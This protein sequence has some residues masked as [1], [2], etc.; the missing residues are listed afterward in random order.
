[1]KF[2]SI[3]IFFN[4]WF[5]L[6]L[7]FLLFTSCSIPNQKARPYKSIKQIKS[8]V[9][10]VTKNNTSK[11]RTDRKVSRIIA[12]AITPVENQRNQIKFEWVGRDSI[13]PNVFDYVI[14]SS[15]V[16]RKNWNNNWNEYKGKGTPLIFLRKDQGDRFLMNAGEVMPVTAHIEKNDTEFK[17]KIFDTLD[18][19]N[20]SEE[21]ARDYTAPIN[22]LTR[23]AKLIP[24]ITAIVKTNQYMD[25]IGLHRMNPFDPNKI[26][27]ILIHGFKSNPTTWVNLINQLQSDPKV[28]NRFQFWTFSYPTGIPILYSTM[29]LRNELNAMR[30]YYDPDENNKNLSNIV[31]VGHS[32]GG[33]IARLLSS[34]SSKEYSKWPPVGSNSF[35]IPIKSNEL[36][37]KMFRFKSQDY[38]TRS[39]FIA[40]PHRGT[41]LASSGIAKMLSSVIQVP[42]E[43]QETFINSLSL[44]PDISF[45]DQQFISRMKSINNLR[46]ESNFIKYMQSSSI[47]PRIKTHSIIGIGKL[48]W[49]KKLESRN[50]FVVSYESAHLINSD[51]ELTIAAWHDL[52]TDSETISEVGRILKS[53]H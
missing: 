18:P 3:Y 32:M 29:R 20:S 9:L 33:I 21:I 19:K 28:R 45:N 6:A 42:F 8:A 24:K 1:M 27:V 5:L 31:L 48:G 15:A 40:T 49:W 43:L 25:G 16:I 26:P 52:N 37:K 44:N 14:R 35:K 46:P 34:T 12:S 51:S 13:D 11:L 2:R 36:A 30:K 53:H 39:I 47:D 7:S 10:D 50:D 41:K 22:Y 23:R 38:I 17:I 4:S